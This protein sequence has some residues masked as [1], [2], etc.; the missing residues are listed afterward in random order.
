MGSAVVWINVESMLI[1][2]LA[3]K[4][5]VYGKAKAI[6]DCQS[7]S[8]DNNFENGLAEPAS[9]NQLLEVNTS[10]N[11]SLRTRQFL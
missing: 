2:S 1:G 3:E 11:G 10:P 9:A 7:G 5:G 6:A 8:P 4:F